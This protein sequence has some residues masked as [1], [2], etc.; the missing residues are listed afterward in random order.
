MNAAVSRT[1]RVTT[2]SCT[3][4]TGISRF[5]LSLG[6]RP[7][8]AFSP[9]RPLQAA[10]IRIEPPPSLAW[11]IGTAPAATKAADPAD[12]APEVCA[13][14][15][16]LRTGTSSWNSA[17]GLKPYSES[18]VLPSTVTPTRPNIRAKSPSAAA[19]SATYACVPC[20]VGRPATSLLSLTKEG[21]PAKK[22]SAGVAA[23]AKAPANRSA[24][25]P[26]SSRRPGGCGRPPPPPPPVA[27]PARRGSPRPGRPRRGRRGRRR[28]RRGLACGCGRHGGQPIRARDLPDM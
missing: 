19:G 9:T 13:V 28:R 23:S 21:R 8:V 22:P 27:R 7:R 26:L 24:A 17:L 3:I 14:C 11:A 25:S 1:E 16:G 12:E 4:C 20:W 18:R 5:S 6:I 2:P 10:G 15:H